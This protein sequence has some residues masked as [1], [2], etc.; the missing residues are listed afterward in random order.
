MITVNKHESGTIDTQKVAESE[1]EIKLFLTPL[2]I[3]CIE[4]NN[5]HLAMKN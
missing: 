1:A 3:L 4:K 5:W 2:I